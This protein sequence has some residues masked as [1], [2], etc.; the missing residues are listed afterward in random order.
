MLYRTPFVIIPHHDFMIRIQS[1]KILTIHPVHLE[2]P[3]DEHMYVL[4]HILGMGGAN[5]LKSVVRLSQASSWFM[6][7]IK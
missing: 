2:A 4:S 1:R 3:V 5:V 6:V 7:V